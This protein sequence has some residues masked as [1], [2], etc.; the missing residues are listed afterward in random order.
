MMGIK[1]DMYLQDEDR[2][3]MTSLTGEM[4]ECR[5]NSEVTTS[6]ACLHAYLITDCYYLLGRKLR[7]YRNVTL[8][9]CQENN[10]QTHFI[11][12]G[13]GKCH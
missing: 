11:A 7:Q 3:N 13:R 9:Y 2:G 1:I 6:Q 4:R 8:D 12:T 10:S 5:T